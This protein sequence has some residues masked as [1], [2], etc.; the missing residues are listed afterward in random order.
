M[1]HTSHKNKRN[2]REDVQKSSTSLRERRFVVLY[3]YDPYTMGTTDRPDLELSLR[4]GEVITVLG[5]MGPD[6]YYTAILPNG[7]LYSS[8]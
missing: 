6:G 5:S 7:K 2:I 1:R 8:L 3:D 4:K